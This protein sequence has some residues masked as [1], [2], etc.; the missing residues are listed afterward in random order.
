MTRRSATAAVIA[1]SLAAIVAG[2]IAPSLI[3]ELDWAAIAAAIAAALLATAFHL[4]MPKPRLAGW[5]SPPG[6]LLSFTLVGVSAVPLLWELGMATVWRELENQEQGAVLLGTLLVICLAIGMLIARDGSGVRDV[7]LVTDSRLL[8]NL[9]IVT[10]LLGLISM[11]ALALSVGGIGTLVTNLATR[12]ELLAGTGPLQAGLSLPAVA[13]I[14][15]LVHRTTTPAVRLLIAGNALV[16]LLAVL[17]IGSRFQALILLLAA[18]VARARMNRLAVRTLVLSVLALVPLSVLYVYQIRQ[19]LSYGRTQ[20]EVDTSSAR[21]F[22]RSTIDPFVDGGV[23][24]LRT[25]GV[26]SESAKTVDVRTEPLVGGIGSIVPRALW[27]GK[28][29]GSA[30]QFSQEFF[31]ERWAQGTGIPPSALAEMTFIFGVAGAVLALGLLGFLA[32][33]LAAA[34]Q[35][36]NS[37]FAILLWPLLS[38]DTVLFA[39]SGSDSF[40]R[41]FLVHIAVVAVIARWSVSWGT[42]LDGEVVQDGDSTSNKRIQSHPGPLDAAL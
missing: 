20:G 35:R 42:R 5:L 36:S 33:R 24:V 41:T 19:Q 9:L 39:K 8:T 4:S 1:G 21:G 7:G 27:P 17:A 40:L 29:D 18:F 23:D 31:P 15:G 3:G 37:V 16:Y 28:P 10:A 13:A 22:L 30:I 38:A 25:L 11:T 14:F 12:R 26:V 2:L 6:L 32:T 34:L